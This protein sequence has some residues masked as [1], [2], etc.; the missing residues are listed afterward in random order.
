LSESRAK[1]ASR[2]QW[3]HWVEERESLEPW[4]DGEWGPPIE[5][6]LGTHGTGH[7]AR[8]L[9]GIHERASRAR[10]ELA[11]EVSRSAKRLKALKRITEVATAR[12]RAQGGRNA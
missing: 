2:E 12:R 7:V 3:L 6:G 9:R 1:V 11:Q 8:D 10:V 4:A 5:T